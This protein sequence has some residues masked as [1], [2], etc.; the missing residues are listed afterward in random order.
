MKHTIRTLGTMLLLAMCIG[1]LQAQKVGTSSLQFLKVMPTARA[2][3]MG[4]AFVSLASGADATFWNPAGLTKIENY[5]MTSTLTMWLF[6]T[7]QLAL[8]YGLPMGDWGT[9]GFQFQYV[10]F[11]SIEETRADAVDLVV[12][13]NGAP[14]FNAGLTG[15]TFTPYSYLVGLSYAR[16]FTDKFSAALTVKYAME[17]L[18]SN[19]TITI[20]NSVTGEVTSYKTYADVVLFDFGMLYNTGFR[21]IQIGIAA[22]NFGPQVTFA[23]AAHPA[24]LAFRLGVSGNLFGQEG[25]LFQDNTNRLTVAYDLFQPNDYRQQM[26]VGAEYAFSELFMLRAGYKYDYDSEGLT[27]GGGLHTDLGNWPVR[28]DY[29]YGKMNEF[30]NTVHRIS[31]GVQFR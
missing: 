20:V 9:L 5:E 23:D 21:S 16:A 22:Q 29:S 25:L 31:L 6:D 24:P 12:P 18:W 28:V 8:A 15:R 7:K 27:F 10:D 1:Q 3:A 14:F 30:L 2:T 11:G 13:A 26:H 19:Q 17:S 4:D